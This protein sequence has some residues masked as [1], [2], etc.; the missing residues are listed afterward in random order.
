VTAPL[1]HTD[2]EPHIGT[3]FRIEAEATPLVEATL[4]EVTVLG[5]APGAADVA[6]GRSPRTPFSLTFH[7][8]R[9]PLLP[10]RIYT[11]VHDAAGRFDIFIVPLGPRGDHMVYE[12]IFN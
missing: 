3:V 6:A 11:F 1:A 4:A 9:E 2:F 8:P 10:Q 5:P 7:G 12:A